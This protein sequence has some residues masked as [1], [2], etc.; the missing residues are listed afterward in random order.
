MN[1][2]GRG[3]NKKIGRGWTQINAEILYIHPC[4]SVLVRV[5]YSD[6]D[7]RGGTRIG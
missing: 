2:E 6:A 4:K 5:L 7:E 3:W 1:A